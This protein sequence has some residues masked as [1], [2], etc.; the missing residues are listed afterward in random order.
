MFRFPFPFFQKEKIDLIKVR[1]LIDDN[2]TT[3]RMS[4]G[5]KN[6]FK[7]FNDPTFAASELRK[8]LSHFQSNK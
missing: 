6:Q 7:R 5:V 3:E 2:V 1:N 8:R 4:E